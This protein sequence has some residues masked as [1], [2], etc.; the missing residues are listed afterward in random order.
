M[1]VFPIR[2][3][4]FISVLTFFYG[5]T[6][7]NYGLTDY[8]DDIQKKTVLLKPVIFKDY[9]S[10]LFKAQVDLNGKYLGGLLF[11][12]QMP[13]GTSRLIMTTETGLQIFDLE[14][15]PD[16]MVV[17]HCYDKLNKKFVL[18][19]IESDFRLLLMD[20]IENQPYDLL[21]DQAGLYTV[22]KTRWGKGLTYY[23]I[24]N[25]TGYLTRIEH[26]SPWYKK[27]SLE[28]T[29]FI[30]GQPNQFLFKHHNIPLQIKLRILKN[31]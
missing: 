27:V 17:H 6:I 22:Y 8:R 3:L 10:V 2:N 19:T 26:S 14:L 21:M 18:L 31:E 20:N 23:F 25:K 11:L 29:G 30:D 24:E 15:F 13:N 7:R 16:S 4:L 5:C 9:T 1:K 28:L 12:K